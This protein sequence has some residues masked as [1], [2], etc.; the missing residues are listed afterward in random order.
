[1][2]LVVFQAYI[3]SFYVCVCVLGG[4]PDLKVLVCTPTEI[5]VSFR[6]FSSI[7]IFM[8]TSFSVLTFSFFTALKM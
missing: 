4:H 1:M 5:F 3:N 8:P 7:M 2:K 6:Y